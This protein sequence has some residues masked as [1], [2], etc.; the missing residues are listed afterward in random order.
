MR[1]SMDSSPRRPRVT[2][3]L[4]RMSAECLEPLRDSNP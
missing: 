3:E 1:R 4:L 2:R